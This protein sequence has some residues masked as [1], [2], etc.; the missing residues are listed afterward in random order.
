MR[1]LVEAIN[2]LSDHFGEQ[3]ALELEDTPTLA[4]VLDVDVES[5]YFESMCKL[6]DQLRHQLGSM[7][8]TARDLRNHIKYGQKWFEDQKVKEDE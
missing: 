1:R 8:A 6:M 3:L 2:T 7:S 4:D 5:E